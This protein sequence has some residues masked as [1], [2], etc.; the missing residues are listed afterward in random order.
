MRATLLVAGLIIA[1]PGVAG[2][3]STKATLTA[4]RSGTPD[5]TES[6]DK[7]ARGIVDCVRKDGAWSGVKR[8]RDGHGYALLAST[9]A[10]DIAEEGERRKVTLWPVAAGGDAEADPTKTAARLAAVKACI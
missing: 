5:F 9:A 4:I 10:L 6:S 8:V 7:Q 3:A 1:L 2:A